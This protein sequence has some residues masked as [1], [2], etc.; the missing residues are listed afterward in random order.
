MTCDT[1]PGELTLA[2]RVAPVMTAKDSNSHH[3]FPTKPSLILLVLNTFSRHKA[4]HFH[5]QAI[6]F[7]KHVDCF[8]CKLFGFHFQNQNQI[9]A[10]V[11]LRA[12]I[13]R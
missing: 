11:L 4:N 5:K 9:Q 10:Q 8:E 7:R 6:L 12:L 13:V 1:R 3:L 2:Q